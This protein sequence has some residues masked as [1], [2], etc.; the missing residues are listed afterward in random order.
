[1]N[2]FEEYGNTSI[3]IGRSNINQAW[4]VWREDSGFQAL[5]RIHNDK[6]DALADY[7]QRNEFMDRVLAA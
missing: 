6:E 1:M 4:M 5:V 7:K 3:H 2:T